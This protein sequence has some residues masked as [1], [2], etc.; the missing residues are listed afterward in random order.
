MHTMSHG[1]GLSVSFDKLSWV[2]NLALFTTQSRLLTTLKEKAFENIVGKGE[3]AG[4][5]NIF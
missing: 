1:M 5:P 4:N 2:H 3:N